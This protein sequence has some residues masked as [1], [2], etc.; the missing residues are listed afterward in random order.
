MISNLR[1]FSYVAAVA[2]HG[3]LVAAAAQL[4]ISPSAI[5]AAIRAC[6]DEF[7]YEIFVRRPAKRLQLTPLGQD[8]VRHVAGILER[9]EAFH[10][11]AR[12]LGQNPVGQVSVGCFSSFARRIVPPV[13]AHLADAHPQLSIALT[14]ADHTG[15]AEGL[16]TGAV[17]AAI[18]Y[19]FVQD[20]SL[21]YEP[22]LEVRP[23]VMLHEAHPLAGEESIHLAQ[24][25]D[26]NLVCID[27]PFIRDYL[28]TLFAA[29]G[30]TP[31]IWRFSKSIG[32]LLSLVAHG[33][34]YSIAFLRSHS[35]IEPGHRLRSI[36]IA[37]AVPT[38]NMVIA[39]NPQM[40]RTRRVDAFTAACHHVMNS[41]G[42][43]KRFQV[44]V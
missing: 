12:G 41:G 10:D 31:R 22:L 26:E 2:K 15:L 6:E 33:L 8:F 16:K 9:F 27:E 7:G 24:V 28:I 17:E 43:K 39:T 32:M 30:L 18:I 42:L 38:H 3:S 4:N 14:E 1:H 25:A 44:G 40:T 35:V 23:Y 37:D 11:A 21:V 36:R 34:G 5:S 20:R 13:M 19:D 29:N